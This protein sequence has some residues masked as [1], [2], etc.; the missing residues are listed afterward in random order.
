MDLKTGM[1]TS[2]LTAPAEPHPHAFVT[3]TND[4]ISHHIC[5]K[6]SQDQR[7][8]LVSSVLYL[9]LLTCWDCIGNIL[10]LTR[11]Q[12]IKATEEWEELCNRLCRP[13]GI[14]RAQVCCKE[15]DVSSPL[16]SSCPGS[17]IVVTI[18][19]RTRTASHCHRQTFG[20]LTAFTCPSRGTWAIAGGSPPFS[21]V[22]WGLDGA[23][24]EGYKEACR[25]Q[26]L[27]SLSLLGG[28]PL[29]RWLYASCFL[30]GLH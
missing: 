9:H 8:H 15:A 11:K 27:L 30:K 5:F 24:R 18:A 4:L 19:I 14:R 28:F 10:E 16:P 13:A 20:D 29:A 26:T 22:G 2:L 1:G 17:E 23:A 12:E 21:P 7:N 6:Y 3:G 25:L